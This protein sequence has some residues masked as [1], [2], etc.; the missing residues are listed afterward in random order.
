METVT[1][2]QS[3]IAAH[4]EAIGQSRYEVEAALKR[5]VRHPAEDDA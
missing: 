1:R 5:V 3:A 4:A 2:V